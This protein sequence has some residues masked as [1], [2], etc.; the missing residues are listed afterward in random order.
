MNLA[1]LADEI[2][3][4]L[5]DA[6]YRQA[7]GGVIMTI[8]A[9]GGITW[10][11]WLMNRQL[12][13][14]PWLVAMLLISLLRGAI[15]FKVCAD[16]S[17]YTTD[18]KVRLFVMPL[19][20]TSLL[21]AIL[22]PLVFPG[23][24]TYEKLALAVIHAGLAGGSVSVLAGLKWSARL[25]LVCMLGPAS[26]M[27]SAEQPY[28]ITLTGLGLAYLAVM[29]VTHAQSR[30]MLMEA[31]L[32]LQENRQ[33][34]NAA[35]TQHGL[36]ER[37]N[38]K[39]LA[40]QSKLQN[41]NN[42][43]EAVVLER[44]EKMRLFAA[45]VEN[46]AEGVIVLDTQGIVLEVNPA[47]THITGLAPSDIVG[48]PLSSLSSSPQEASAY[49]QMWQQLA[50]TGR[51]EGE[52]WSRKPNGDS[53]LERRSV[54]SV[55]NADG[56]ISHYVL[57]FNDIT[58]TRRKDERIRYLAYHDTLTGLPNRLLLEDRLR[59]SI[60]L[61][62]RERQSLAVMFLDIDQF[63]AVNDGLGHAVGDLLLQQVAK[64]LQE[65]LRS[66]D[67]LGRLGGDEF[68]VLLQRVRHG[69]RC[70]MLARR[71]ADALAAPLQVLSHQIHIGVSIGIAVYPDDGTDAATLMK[72]A[73]TAMYEAKTAGRGT[74]RYFQSNMSERA[75]QRLELDL[76]LRQAIQRNEFSLEYQ[77]K[78][79]ACSGAVVGYEALL[80][81]STRKRGSVPPSQ[82]VPVAEDT[83]LIT[84]IGEWAL[85]ESCRQ[86][87]RW[88]AMGLES[89]P[90]AINVSSRQLYAGDLVNQ[91][92]EAVAQTAISPALLEI[93]VTESVLM[94]H[95]K[96][97]IETL[98]ALKV[99]GVRVAIDDFGTGYSSLAYLR[100]LPIDVLKIDRSFVAEVELDING[101]AIVK[102]IL[103][104]GHTLGLTV[105]A[106]GVETRSQAELLRSL[107]C[108]QLQGFLFATPARG[109]QI[110]AELLGER[111]EAHMLDRTTRR[112]PHMA[113]GL[114]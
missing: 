108:D 86:I 28:G 45:A 13:N 112:S 70:A 53:F 91:V 21:W 56:Q 22:S 3:A 52:L 89:Q 17:R 60:T 61:A 55:R 104:L 14:P 10:L 111:A 84:Q 113:Q 82:F 9:I 93:E 101:L 38:E 35:A 94:A 5:I 34:S 1:E 107:G 51:W 62:Q 78:V 87:A 114:E 39:L 36:V 77:P 20:V 76:D 32:R 18:L 15:T 110:A 16:L 92:R 19:L 33:L 27:L 25:Y 88:E 68:L 50:E 79:D 85:V 96:D 74:F 11:H 41:Q 83:G 43:L 12:L 97:V 95:P 44:T 103:A 7:R 6:T 8:V 30:R 40:A 80:R 64:R 71:I 59:Q 105:I 23:I 75:A 102:T 31:H 67:T 54:D 57:V 100:Q 65:Q 37:L 2:H 90:V 47:F 58:D 48:R 109:E 98:Q 49:N 106:E 72:N 42:S 63:K 69:H 4:G 26:V 24:D 99:L 46:T 29:L 81:W 66:S 73:D